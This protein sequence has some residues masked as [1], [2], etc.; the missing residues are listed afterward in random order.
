[1][2][3]P[4]LRER[5][6]QEVRERISGIATLLFLERGFDAVS[7]AEIAEAAGVSKMT[8]FNY[9][10]RKEELFFDR[11]PQLFDMITTAVRDREPGVAATDALL[12]LWLGLFDQRHALAGMHDEVSTFWRVVLGSPALR[13]RV[14][15]ALEEIETLVAELFAEA[16]QPEPEMTAALALAAVRVR[17]VAAARRIM[18]GEHAESFAAEQRASIVAAWGAAVAAGMTN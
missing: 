17:Y 11:V 6:K 8:V 1:M 10:P 12:A 18:S 5:K 15:E 3:R 14:R 7:V 4:G 16:G 2:T 9:F 13:A